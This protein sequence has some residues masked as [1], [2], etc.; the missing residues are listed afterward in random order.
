MYLVALALLA[1]APEPLLLSDCE[2]ADRWG[3]VTLIDDARVGERAI[4]Y[5]VPAGQAASV[6]LDHSAV[7]WDPAA[8]GELRFWYR[9]TGEGTT[10]L[11]VK[12]LAWPFADG[13]QATWMVDPDPPVDEQWHQAVVDLQSPYLAWGEGGDRS[14]VLMIRTQ[15]GE[16]ARLTL[17]LDQVEVQPALFGFTIGPARVE[18]GLLRATVRVT[19]RHDAP[20]R[21]S[22]RADGAEEQAAE[23]AP[24]ATVELT[25]SLPVPAEEWAALPALGVLRRSARLGLAGRPATDKE[26]IVSVT[27]PLDL[28]PHPRL[29]ATDAELAALRERAGRQEWLARAM[30]GYVADADAWLDREIELPPRGGQWWHWYADP[31]TG[32]TLQTVSPTEHRN[33]RTGE[34]FTGYPYD[35][36]VLSR[37]HDNL[38]RAVMLCG[39]AYRWT[40]EAKYAERAKEILLAYARRY[41][42]Y[43]LHNIHG[44]PEIGGGKVGPQTLD[45]SV[46]LIPVAQGAD[47]IWETL[48]DEER[49]L[50][51]TG[52]FRPAVE[53]IRQHRMSIH[54]IQCWKN[55][56]VGLVGLL[57]GDAELVADAVTSPHGYYEQ[58]ARGVT[59]DGQW[60]EGAWGYHW[61]TMSALVP[62]TEAGE[63]CGLGLYGFERDG[64]SFK[65]LFDG[66]LALAMPDLRLPAFNDSGLSNVGGNTRFYELGLARYAD[67]SYVR[68][69]GARRGGDPLSVIAAVETLPELPAEAT[70]SRVYPDSGYAILQAGDGPAATWLCLKYG[71]HGGG[72]GHPDKLNVALYARGEIL[73]I[74]PGTTRYGVPLQQE[75]FRTTIAHNTLTV[76]ET[77]QRPATGKLLAFAVGDGVSAACAAAGGIYDGVDYRRAVALFGTD[78]VLILD[79]V[80][81]NAEQTYD[82]AYHHDGAWLDP[83]AGAALTMPEANGYRHLEMVALTGPPPP[84]RVGEV[85]ATVDVI[86]PGG[87]IWAGTGLYRSAAERV[88][89]LI[90]RLRGRGARV[91]WAIGLSG[92]R[93]ALRLTETGLEAT[94]GGRRYSL[95]AGPETG[96]RAEGPDGLATG[97]W[98]V[99]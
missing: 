1:A 45:E 30:A 92:E 40:G 56:A 46:W 26:V 59:L 33:P 41:D 96:L 55:S 54:N 57:L 19:S 72:H 79:Q 53:V 98:Q 37:D 89:C 61:Y 52:L 15:A 65:G 42:S 4:R 88:P 71:P 75:W 97:D 47:L 35:D 22:L 63:R 36:V 86:A 7:E 8:G 62:L 84:V 23:V 83:P 39:L 90:A 60:Y 43:P 82:F 49:E 50:A 11:M 27:K 85:T 64:R 29:L 16:G 32:E 10:T 20:L 87:E 21:L 44:R 93:A 31:K 77:S 5:A 70:G 12:L 99:D 73:A 2:S 69:L 18:A 28:P 74:D 91:G 51:E 78:L 17:D 38:A 24:G 34:V 9:L 48:T 3:R 95:V 94:V 6:N 13:H 80:E 68:V 66:P 76:D 67:P 14:R 58:I 81:S 25:F